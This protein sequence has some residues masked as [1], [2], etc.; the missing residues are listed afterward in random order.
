MLGIIPPIDGICPKCG[1]KFLG[2]KHI[3]NIRDKMLLDLNKSEN[4]E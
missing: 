2:I 3:C 1:K 4:N